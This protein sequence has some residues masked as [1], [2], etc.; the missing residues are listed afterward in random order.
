MRRLLL[1]SIGV[2]LIGCSSDVG[3]NDSSKCAKWLQAPSFDQADYVKERRTD[4]GY[5]D[6]ATVAGLVERRCE[7]LSGSA[8]AHDELVGPLIDDAVLTHRAYAGD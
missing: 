4:L 8:G 2:L 1:I 7:A 5:Q 6:A 3:L